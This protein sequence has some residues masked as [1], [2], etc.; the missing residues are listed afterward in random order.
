MQ[1][2]QSSAHGSLWKGLTLK[3]LVGQKVD[4]AR[5]K[6]RVSA[7]NTTHIAQHIHV[8][9]RMLYGELCQSAQIFPEVR[10]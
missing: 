7:V 1:R 2:G 9:A 4:G 10:G 6:K 3:V 5:L 8:L